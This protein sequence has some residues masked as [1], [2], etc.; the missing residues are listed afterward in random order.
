MTSTQ[1]LNEIRSLDFPLF[2]AEIVSKKIIQNLLC[3]LST[4]PCYENM[5]MPN[6]IFFHYINSISSGRLASPN[7]S[8]QHSLLDAACCIQSSLINIR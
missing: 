2:N 3:L 6:L 1:Y 5:P 4:Q 7:H 8:G